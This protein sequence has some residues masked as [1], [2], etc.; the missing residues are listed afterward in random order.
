[1]KEFIKIYE[2]PVPE[3]SLTENQ[4]SITTSISYVNECN[5]NRLFP[6]G[7][8]IFPKRGGA[9]FTNKKGFF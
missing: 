8:I 1:M 6:F 7:S 9:I 2:R 5:E 3:M 4:F